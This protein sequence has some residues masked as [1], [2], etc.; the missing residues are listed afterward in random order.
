[1]FIQLFILTLVLVGISLAGLGVRLLLQPHSRFP[2][3]HISRNRE[4]QRRGIRCAKETDTGCQLCDKNE[5]CAGS[6]FQ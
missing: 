1:M 2:E 5:G 3:T 4:M 6:H